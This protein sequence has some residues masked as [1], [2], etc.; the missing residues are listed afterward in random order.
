M[1]DT[2][3]VIEVR[4]LHT[5]F[6]MKHRTVFAVNGVSYDVD[7]GEIV[8]IV[9][10]SGC[11]KSVTQMSS[12]QLVASPPGKI[13]KGQVVFNGKNLLDYGRDSEEIR[14]I[15]GSDIAMIFQEPMTSLNPVLTI[16]E[17]IAETLR[18]HKG[19]DKKQA[20]ERVIELLRM[21]GIPDPQTRYGQYPHEFSGGMCQ[22]IMIAMAISCDPKLLIADEAT[23]ALDVTTQAQILETLQ[24]IVKETH[25]ALIIVTHNLGIVARY[26]DRIYV[27]YAGRIVESGTA[28]QI[29]DH[30]GHAYTV[31]LLNSIPRLDDDRSRALVPIDGLPP[32]LQKPAEHC[33]FLPRCRQAVEECARL[34]V[35]ELME[36]QPGHYS[37]CYNHRL[38]TLMKLS[39]SR[40][41][42]KQ[43]G[44]PVL[45]VSD[46][47]MG[48]MV[49]GKG[50]GKKAAPLKILEGV[51]FELRKGE[52]LGL[53]GE[54][55]CG[56]TTVAKCILR[57]LT[58][59]SGKILFNGADLASMKEAQLRQLRKKIQLVFQDP[60]GSLD[61]RQSIG[62]IVGEPL[63]VHKLVHSKEA[64]D[65]RVQSLFEMVG[66]DYSMHGRAP[67]ELSGG[68]RQR[69]GI[70]RALASEPEV[71]ICDEPVS[72]LDVSVQ[73]Q[74]LNLL[75]KLQREMNLSYIF[76][77]HD[78]SVVRHISDRIA[79]MYLGKIVE[80]GTCGQ[81]YENPV[82]PYTKALLSAIPIPSPQ[83]EKQR[84][85]QPL[86]G[87]M[88]SI[89]HRPTGCSFH[90]R[91]PFASE[92]CVREEQRL[93]EVEP[94]HYAACWNMTDEGSVL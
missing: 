38:D 32:D 65:R 56:K 94:L 88:P 45:T 82:H 59:T 73:A 36:C 85:R 74:I 4:D 16:G 60:F 31:G 29:F 61:P 72:A 84:K 51:D 49:K 55:G 6:R 53:V 68:Q 67:H 24:K 43:L 83:V 64:Y 87:E 44:G 27:M 3:K 62:D 37:A 14:A 35:P 41:E 10:E 81:L 78:L 89:S 21:V 57:L 77:A 48:F 7:A 63:H 70:A 50:L 42:E 69:I 91:C 86:L 39:D 11:G 8:G 40:V 12:I 15:R 1:T 18:L 75:E 52:T 92:R 54:S 26:A 30:P 93:K 13:T 58:P 79:V 23:T 46:L 66:L 90:P 20:R 22:R 47:H 76:I 19:L 2:Q 34:P 71:I 5:E 28:W 25:T 80:T 17:Q 9:G 33:P